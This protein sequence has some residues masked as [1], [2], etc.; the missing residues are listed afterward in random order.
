MAS[1]AKEGGSPS[2]GRRQGRGMTNKKEESEAEVEK[3]EVEIMVE[4]YTNRVK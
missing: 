3:T 2:P 4:D 1:T